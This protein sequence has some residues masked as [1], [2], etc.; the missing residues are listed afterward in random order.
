MYTLLGELD[1]GTGEAAGA[2]VSPPAAR[3][4]EDD[5]RDPILSACI[6]ILVDAFM[7]KRAVIE[8]NATLSKSDKEQRMWPE[9]LQ[10]V[11]NVHTVSALSPAHRTE[12]LALR[13]LITPEAFWSAQHN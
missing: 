1:D 9:E 10:Y 3:A 11:E 4:A 2:A 13:G 7:A 6:D 12:M 5:D 8:A